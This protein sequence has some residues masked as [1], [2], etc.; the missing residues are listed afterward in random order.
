MMQSQRQDEMD[1]FDMEF[2][3]ELW[4]GFVSEMFFGE[5]FLK[6]QS[7]DMKDSGLDENI[8]KTISG[9]FNYQMIKD[10]FSQ[11]KGA[12]YLAGDYVYMLARLGNITLDLV[13][14]YGTFK[15]TDV[16][17]DFYYQKP[18]EIMKILAYDTRN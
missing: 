14:D 2:E 18:K 15:A 8:A 6:W 12:P 1:E 4:A 3:A 11:G 17:I 7:Q 13:Q 5:D 10:Y 9:A 16:I